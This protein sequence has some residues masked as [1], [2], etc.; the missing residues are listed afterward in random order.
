MSTYERRSKKNP[1]L[2]PDFRLGQLLIQF[3]IVT[4]E[5]ISRGL[6]LSSGAGLPLGKALVLLDCIS[7]MVLQD[8]VQAQSMLRDG[9]IDLSQANEA[10]EISSRMKISI[11]KAL[12]V[13]EVRLGGLDCT[14]LGN[15]LKAS[16][17][18]KKDQ[19]EVGLRVASNSGL[20]LGQVLVELNFISQDTLDVTLR[21][22]RE[23]REGEPIS[24]RAL[25]KELRKADITL[26]QLPTLDTQKVMLGELL[27]ESG[28]VDSTALERALNAQQNNSM[29]LG[30]FLVETNVIS[31]RIL[32]LALNL[33]LL[34]F[35]KKTTRESA[36]L[37]IKQ[38]LEQAAK[39]GDFNPSEDSFSFG[40]FLTASNYLNIAREQEVV[41]K[42]EQDAIL[43][44]RMQRM[45]QDKSAQDVRSLM[46]IALKNKAVLRSLLIEVMPHEREVLD[47]AYVLYLMILQ[48]KMTS[49]Q[50][51]VDFTIKRNRIMC[52]HQ[53]PA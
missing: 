17:K 50:A 8:V 20:P 53:K 34:I 15:L 47:C 35:N 14:R 10:F 37:T 9:L 36:I 21:L 13:L 40:D 5:D 4:G 44:A 31:D 6:R 51:I 1:A 25:K 39:Q 22:Q 24:N 48:K 46:K 23:L 18:I 41:D 11:E 43:C 33:Q 49:C 26:P 28:V 52:A 2:P 16:H 29:P 30:Q 12:V 27:V 42:L 19:L 32:K 38:A 3:G 45:L 7:D